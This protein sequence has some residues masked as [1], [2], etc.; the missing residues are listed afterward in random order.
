MW[1]GSS[2]STSFDC[3]GFV[4]HFPLRGKARRHYLFHGNNAIM[5][6]IVENFDLSMAI[7]FVSVIVLFGLSYVL[8]VTLFK[9][10]HV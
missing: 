3:S 7:S 6:F 4:Y 9:K 1:G 10:K 8:S 5:G 2:P